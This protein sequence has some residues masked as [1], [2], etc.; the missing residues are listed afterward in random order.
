MKKERPSQ[1]VGRMTPCSS[2]T[3]ASCPTSAARAHVRQKI[4]KK[5]RISNLN[6]NNISSF[7]SEFLQFN[8]NN[9]QIAIINVLN[10]RDTLFLILIDPEKIKMKIQTLLAHEEI[11]LILY[12]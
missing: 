2:S 7:S 12:F 1:G 4:A 9:S 3:Y 10:C 5:E 8:E 6:R 11:H